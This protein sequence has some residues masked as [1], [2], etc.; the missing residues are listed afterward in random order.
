MLEGW[1]VER[2]LDCSVNVI[3]IFLAV[4]PRERRCTDCQSFHAPVGLAT[5]SLCTW[6]SRPPVRKRAPVEDLFSPLPQLDSSFCLVSRFLLSH[7]TEFCEQACSSI[8]AAP[9]CYAPPPKA[10]RRPK[11]QAAVVMPFIL[12]DLEVQIQQLYESRKQPMA[13][14]LLAAWLVGAG[15]ASSV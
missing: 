9:G 15:W 11:G 5:P 7:F 10:I 1:N 6:W 13:G 2:G 8:L 14:S 3:C 12:R 4:H